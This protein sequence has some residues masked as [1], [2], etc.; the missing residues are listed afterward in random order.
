MES[1]A[2]PSFIYKLANLYGTGIHLLSKTIQK[3]AADFISIMITFTSCN[4]NLKILFLNNIFHEAK[5]YHYL[6]KDEFCYP[7]VLQVLSVLFKIFILKLTEI[8]YT[9]HYGKYKVIRNHI[10]N[11]Y[12]KN[13]VQ[14]SA[15]WS[16]MLNKIIP[17]QSYSLRITY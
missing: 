14:A 11:K 7:P 1:N 17:P 9:K 5:V 15:I 10:N 13:R 12:S 6:I 8:L 4:V 2:D 3:F 16:T